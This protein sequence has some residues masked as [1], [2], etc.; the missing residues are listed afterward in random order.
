MTVMVI[1]AT[2]QKHLVDDP[3]F[4][5][6]PRGLAYLAFTEMWE[7]FSFYGMQ[8]LLVLYMTQ[9]LLLPGQ[10]EDIVG[11]AT[12]RAVLEGVLG[13]LSAQALAGQTFGLYA[14]LV[15]FTPLIGGW[16]ADRW[17]G[18]KRTVVVGVLLMTAGH[19][20][21]VFD[22]SFLL[23]LLLLIL[24][25]GALKGNI[26]AQVGQLY[27]Q[28]DQRTTRA[29]AI[30]ST[31]INIG[32]ILGPL[33]CGTLAQIYG[34]HIGFGAAGLLMLLALAVYL[35]GFRYMPDE[36]PMSRHRAAQPSL[37]APEWRAMGLLAVMLVMMVV[38]SVGFDQ[39][40]NMGMVWTDAQVAL[41]TRYGRFPVAWFVSIN[42]VSIV[43]ASFAVIVLW[44][45]QAERGR[46]TRDTTKI[47]IGGA[48]TGFGVTIL[49]LGS[50]LGTAAPAHI[51]FPIAAFLISGV[52]FAWF[53]PTW[54][55]LVARHA[56]PKIAGR[57][58]A[59][60]YLVVFVSS[61]LGGFVATYYETMSPTL[62]WTLNA[63]MCF[64]G[65]AAFFVFGPALTR[66]LAGPMRSE[67]IGAPA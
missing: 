22:Q 31:G 52:G 15:Y 8:S 38:L 67:L 16:V 54:L 59:A 5:G 25:S 43:L 18:A 40:F 27:R 42:A 50:A 64:F 47:A 63:A 34:W 36:S 53:W 14:G 48:L 24:G 26:A 12:Y 6:H 3:T 49:A 45:R 1:T 32:A 55:A 2:G 44:R 61:V 56:P 29:F 62:F 37:T 41:D 9:A 46:E 23:A 19:A 39:M 20:A 65:S 33:A 10:S 21:M 28:E 51:A 35:A 4:F 60:A 11:M 7:R 57:M 66:A 30:F 13:P 58:M 17:L